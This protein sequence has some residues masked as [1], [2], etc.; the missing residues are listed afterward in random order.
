MMVVWKRLEGGLHMLEHGNAAGSLEG[1]VGSVCPQG[2]LPQRVA[3]I[4]K[5]PGNSAGSYRARAAMMLVS[6][7]PAS[8]TVTGPFP[9][10][11]SIDDRSG[12]ED[13]ENLILGHRLTVPDRDHPRQRLA[14]SA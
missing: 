7:T 9:Q 13:P 2:K 12:R 5:V 1:I 11:I 8:C 6:T 3:V 10:F 14:R 4:R